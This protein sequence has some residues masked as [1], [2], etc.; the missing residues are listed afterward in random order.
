MKGFLGEPEDVW[1]FVGHRESLVDVAEGSG[2]VQVEGIVV[3]SCK[4]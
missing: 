1:L 3:E 2:A 4:G